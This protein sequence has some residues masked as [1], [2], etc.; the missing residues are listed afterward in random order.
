MEAT[1]NEDLF[2]SFDKCD[3]DQLD[4]LE[5]SSLKSDEEQTCR[6]CK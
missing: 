5:D 3:G 2:E 4:E 1:G 6:I